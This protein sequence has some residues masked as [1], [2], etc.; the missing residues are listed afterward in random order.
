MNLHVPQTEGSTADVTLIMDV[1]E[2]ILSAQNNAPII[3]LKQ[4]A[5]LGVYLLT[6]YEMI[7]RHVFYNVIMQFNIDH[8][9]FYERANKYYPD[10]FLIKHGQLKPKKKISGKILC[11]ILLPKIFHYTLQT[12]TNTTFPLV[13]IERGIVLPDSGPWCK[14]TVATKGNTIQHYLAKEFSLADAIEFLSNIQFIVYRWMPT[15]GFT[16]GIDDCLITNYDK[17]VSVVQKAMAEYDAKMQIGG[18]L[19]EQ[20][21]NGILNSVT[22]VGLT[23]AKEG[24]NY[25]EFNHIE[26][27]QKSG[28]KGSY[29]NV[30]QITALLGQQNVKGRRIPKQLTNGRRCLPFYAPGDESPAARAF[31]DKSFYM[32]LTPQQAFFHAQGS[33]EGLVDTAIKTAKS[34][35]IQ[36]RIVKKTEDSKVHYDYSVRSNNGRIIQYTYGNDAFDASRLYTVEGKPFFIDPKRII[37][38]L[39]C[40]VKETPI[41]L[42][43]DYITSI[44][45]ELKISKLDSL[46]VSFASQKIQDRFRQL[47]DG[48][49]L[50]PSQ[51]EFFKKKVMT[52]FYKSQVAPGEMSGIVASLSIGEPTTQGTLNVF[53]MSGVAGKDVTLGVPRLEECLDCTKKPSTPSC[54]IYLKNDEL[55]RLEK[56]PNSNRECLIL[57]KS[58]RKYFQHITIESLLSQHPAIKY[59]DEEQQDC[60]PI[61]IVKPQEFEPE[62]WVDVYENTFC[63]VPRTDWIIELTFDMQKL[64]EFDFTVKYIA[65]VIEK[66]T[67]ASLKCIPSPNVIGKI[68]ICPDF[69]YAEPSKKD[70][71]KKDPDKKTPYT[72]NLLITEDNLPYFYARDIVT[73]NVKNIC[74]GGVEGISKVFPRVVNGEWVLDTQGSNFGKLANID[75]CNFS[76]T[77]CDDFWQVYKM[78]GIEAVRTTLLEELVKCMSFDGGYI[79]KRHIEILVDNM[80]VT[81]TLTSVR[82]YGMDKTAGPVK[83][84][85]FE[86]PID[87][88]VEA[89]LFGTRENMGMKAGISA[90]I[91]MGKVARMGTGFID[92]L[93]NNK[94]LQ[95]SREKKK[96]EKELILKG[97]EDYY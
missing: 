97:L 94:L 25:G 8:Q 17:V 90:E 81:G 50:V 47:V 6:S 13:K 76:K 80:T 56:Y 26:Q 21:L 5:L 3:G 95:P 54:L 87:H 59:V 83:N 34:G 18:E 65:D 24:L 69:T 2:R 72:E 22:N 71:L 92:V 39:N 16:I 1:L 93:P 61:S 10:S 48:Q 33:R 84:I 40:T 77:K 27:M 88:I 45:D 63:P 37:H 67:F 75:Q 36:R 64:Y 15:R 38:A 79:N 73:E 20:E 46:N 82:R 62:W 89:G 4:D 58:M 28:A 53:H 85:A 52:M 91:L 66:S 42:T 96:S 44:C 23:L 68:I 31:I 43:T 74:L 55:R 60:T 49:W 9:E 32:G 30:A 57:V 19:L 41:E 14:K 7:P 12:D 78:L 35:Y 29:I 11:S 51:L 86:C 70:A